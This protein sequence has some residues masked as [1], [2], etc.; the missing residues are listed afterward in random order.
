[1]QQNNRKWGGVWGG[2]KDW[3]VLVHVPLSAFCLSPFSSALHND[4]AATSFRCS[5]ACVHI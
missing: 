3:L 1:M 4:S 2:E 5:F